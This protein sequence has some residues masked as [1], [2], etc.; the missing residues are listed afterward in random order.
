[1]AGNTFAGLIWM[2]VG[3]YICARY[4]TADPRFL[5]FAAFLVSQAAMLFTWAVIAFEL[6]IHD[7]MAILGCVVILYDLRA[8]L[9]GV[10]VAFP[11]LKQ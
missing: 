11:K 7:L 3:G 9:T 6:S 8:E 4:Y 2:F 10:Q 5:I 1:M